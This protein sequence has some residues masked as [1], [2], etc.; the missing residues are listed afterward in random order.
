MVASLTTKDYFQL[1]KTGYSTREKKKLIVRKNGRSADFIIPNA[2]MGCSYFCNYCYAARNR[3]QGNP[4]ELFTNLDEIIEEVKSHASTLPS[5]VPNQCCNKYYTYDIGEN[6]DCLS[7]PLLETTNR[8]LGELVEIPNCKPSFATKA[9]SPTRV[10]KLINCPIPYKARVR[11]SL[12]P[13]KVADIVEVG[14]AKMVDRLHGLNLAYSKG[15][16]SHINLS[17]VILTKTWVEDYIELFKLINS[18]LT[19]EV[20]SQLKLEIIYLTHSDRLH[21]LNLE[22]IPQ[23]ERLL[24]VPTIQEYKVNNR[25]S[26]VLRYKWQIKQQAVAK[27]KELVKQYLPSV[28]IRYIF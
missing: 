13:Q 7:P 19:P 3:P 14:T 9:G 22:W 12:S 21:E 15:F 25:G 2:S 5:K 26:K 10:A 4:I 23:A 17:P 20:K 6:S 18:T 24:W 8:L 11:A 1:K 27:M 16:E 28:E